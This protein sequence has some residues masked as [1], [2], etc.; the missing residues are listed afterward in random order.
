MKNKKNYL[1]YDIT[2]ALLE[3][4]FSEAKVADIRKSY[5]E[6]HRFYHNFEHLHSIVS[7][8]KT[9]DLDDSENDLLY[10]AAAYHDIVYDPKNHPGVNESESVKR[11]LKDVKGTG[12]DKDEPES[13]DLICEIIE[14]TAKRTRPLSKLP[15]LFWE[16]D[17]SILNSGFRE[18]LDYEDKIFKEYQYVSYS[19]YK[20]GRIK[21]LEEEIKR[22]NNINLLYLIEYVNSRKP[23]IGLYPGSF[24]PFHTGHL[25][26]LQKAEQI[27]DKVVIVKGKNPEK[28]YAALP[29]SE[30][31]I[32]DPIKNREIYEWNGLTTDLIMELSE[33]Y[34]VT[35]VRGLRNGKDLDYEVNQLR[36][37]ES[38]YKDLKV[39]Y[40]P[41]DKEFEHI[42]SSA[43]RNIS[44]FS[45]KE[46][47]KY[48]IK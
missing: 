7:S 18:L 45:E 9:L 8:I 29:L 2:S 15:G 38:M 17:N 20:Q 19:V 27:F 23:R 33:K 22:T 26:V 32:P 31:G 11:F 14:C 37:M 42:S 24:F 5:L 3:N 10:I 44:L 30:I 25:N 21:F 16:I 35:L 41:C 39:C 12:Y 28:G 13:I 43:I 47:E 34:D 6:P 40:I 36:F 1:H 48:L 46:I 4:G